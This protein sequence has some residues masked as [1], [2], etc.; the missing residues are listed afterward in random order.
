LFLDSEVALTRGNPVSL[1]AL[2]G[3]LHPGFGSFT[4]MIDA[5]DEDPALFGQ[6]IFSLGEHSARISFLCPEK[7]TC[8]MS[9][10]LLLDGL[11]RKAGEWGAFNLV[12]EVE[13]LNP[14]FEKLRRQ[15]F[16]VYAWQRI[17]QM[18]PGT[19]PATGGGAWKPASAADEI[20]MRSLFQILVPPLVQSAEP[21]PARRPRALVY[22]VKDELLAYVDA[23]FGPDGIFLQPLFHPDVQNLAELLAELVNAVSPL[24]GRPVYLCVRSYQAWL[25]TALDQMNTR[26]APRRALLVKR[27][28]LAQRAAVPSRLAVLEKRQAEPTAPLVQNLK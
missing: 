12:A 2:L 8:T 27:L 14:L 13:E 17:W 16:S 3:Q 4:G 19:A 18:F 21:W 10:G 15:S 7:N 22:R 24:M 23:R 1:A 6:V 11:I 28:A 20:N 9:L 25:E 26:A 5:T